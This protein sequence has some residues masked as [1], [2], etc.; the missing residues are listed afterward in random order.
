MEFGVNEWILAVVAGLCIGMSKAGFGGLAMVSVLIMATILPAKQSTGAV[1][2]LLIVADICAVRVFHR[3]AEWKYI[4]R[5]FL[6]AGVGVVIGYFIMEPIPEDVF[7]KVIGL[8]VL[9]MVALHFL[10]RRFP[11]LA[12]GNRHLTAVWVIGILCGITTMLANAAGA[13]MTLYL[14][15]FGLHKM[16]F[17]GTAAWYFL[18]LNLF[19]VPFSYSLGLIHW[20]SL[21]LN[22]VLAPVVVTGV[23]CGHWLLQRVPQKLFEAL[24]LWF[25]LLA[26]AR[27]AFFP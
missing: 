24:L 15:S 11:V 13:I 5:L 2:P 26:A 4:H 20:D 25:A 10:Q 9:S 16:V 23:L 17:V 27:L 7:R 3:H 12:R 1:L 6:P 14:L 22:L 8:I 21:F 19:K 18:F